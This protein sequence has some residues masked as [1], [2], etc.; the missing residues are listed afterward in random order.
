MTRR[1]VVTGIGIVS[2]IG[3]GTDAFWRALAGGAT[4]IVPAASEQ[5]AAGARVIAPVREFSARPYVRNERLARVLNRTFELLAGAAALAGADAGLETAPVPEARLGVSAGLGAIDQY[6]SDLVAAAR[7]SLNGDG[8]RFNLSRFGE[9]AHLLYPLR[10]LRLLPNIG[11]SLVSIIHHAGGPSMTF[12]GG[13]T[14]GL[15]AIAEALAMIRAGRADAILCGGADSRVSAIALGVFGRTTPLS[16]S[17]DPDTACRPFDLARDGVVAGEGAA[18]LVLEAEE[19]A[20]ARG[21]RAR[22][23]LLASVSASEV[24]GKPSEDGSSCACAEAMRRVL[25]EAGGALPDAVVAHGDGGIESDRREAGALGRVLRASSAPITSIQAAVGHTM[26]A[27][28]PLNVATACLMIGHGRVP[29]IRSLERPEMD[30]PFAVGAAVARPLAR[31]LVN[32]LEP[33]GSATSALLTSIH[34]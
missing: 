30:L 20:R 16:A 10:R 33:D 19:S 27:S 1:V 18:V 28:G 23:E 11:P 7:A 17:D 14:A 29:A 26:S 21:A 2:P 8:G 34:S 25:D 6:T 9:A 5:A 22:A 13:H 4:G 3:I 12:V 32:A 24:A 15:Q 31:V